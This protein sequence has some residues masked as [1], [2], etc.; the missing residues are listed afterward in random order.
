[1]PTAPHQMSYAYFDYDCEDYDDND[2]VFAEAES[3]YSFEELVKLKPRNPLLK[4]VEIDHDGDVKGKLII[5][6]YEGHSDAILY[7]ELEKMLKL[8]NDG[9]VPYELVLFPCSSTCT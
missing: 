5:Q 7:G 4:G 6:D 8:Y 1:M 2:D 3:F 9:G